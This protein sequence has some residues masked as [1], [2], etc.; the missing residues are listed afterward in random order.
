MDEIESS[1]DMMKRAYVIFEALA[2]ENPLAYEPL[3]ANCG[4][5]IAFLYRKIG[6][7]ET[8]E[9]ILLTGLEILERFAGFNPKSFEVDLAM[10]YNSLGAL[11]HDKSDFTTAETYLKKAE[12]IYEKLGM[13]DTLGI[14]Y[15]LL[16]KVYLDSDNLASAEIYFDKTIATVQQLYENQ[17]SLYIMGYAYHCNQIAEIYEEMELFEKAEALYRRE[18]DLLENS[19]NEIEE[20]LI[21]KYEYMIEFLKSIGKNDDIPHF[22][23]KLKRL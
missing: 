21:E 14:S 10:S 17:P 13:L 18:I 2:R 6:E 19:D 4:H 20:M 22:E 3:Y 23:D 11:Y 12:T 8:A 15:F 1:I 5:N 16:G 7:T 9:T